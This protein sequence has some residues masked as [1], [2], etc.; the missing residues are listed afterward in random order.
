MKSLPIV[1][2]KR[3]PTPSYAFCINFNHLFQCFHISR[4]DKLLLLV[5]IGDYAIAA[6][7][8]K[9]WYLLTLGTFLFRML[10]SLPLWFFYI[11]IFHRLCTTLSLESTK[12]IWKLPFPSSTSN[13]HTRAHSHCITNG[14]T[15]A[16]IA[17]TPTVLGSRVHTGVQWHVCTR[18]P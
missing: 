14:G 18:W 2:C 16:I 11:C 7:V 12:C 1:L 10:G 8:Y 17:S 3:L 5:T 4:C 9:L 13:T 15:V 6:T